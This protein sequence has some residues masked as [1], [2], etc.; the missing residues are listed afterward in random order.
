MNNYI[1]V[2]AKELKVG[3]TIIHNYSS[4]LIKEC[5]CGLGAGSI[6][7]GEYF[8]IKGSFVVKAWDGESTDSFWSFQEC[9]VIKPIK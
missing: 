2:K 7:F 4:F 6:E 5:G 3:D 1:I 9:P 8:W